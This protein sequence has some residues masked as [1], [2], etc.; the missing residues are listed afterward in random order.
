M[1]RCNGVAVRTPVLIIASEGVT[2]IVRPIISFV[3][4]H[5]ET[6]EGDTGS[7]LFHAALR[8]PK[9][10]GDKA[11][12]ARRTIG[13]GCAVRIFLLCTVPIPAGGLIINGRLL[14]FENYVQGSG[15]TLRTVVLVFHGDMLGDTTPA[16]AE[17]H[18]IAGYRWSSVDRCLAQVIVTHGC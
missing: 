12:V 14:L 7:T 4:F 9:V 16:A 13:D 17:K 18:R 1:H 11:I 3:K 8:K 15:V 5:D 10:G 2:I 6:L